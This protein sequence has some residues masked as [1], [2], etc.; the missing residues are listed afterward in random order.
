MVQQQLEDLY[1]LEPGPD[2]AHYVRAGPRAAHES[3]L[4]READGM[5]EVALELPDYLVVLTARPFPREPNSGWL[6]LIEGVSHF[7]YVAERARTDLPTTLLELELQAE[8]DKFVLLGLGGAHPGLTRIAAHEA[9][10]LYRTLYDAVRYLHPAGTILGDRYRAASDLAARF[11]V[12]L[13]AM[14]SN[15]GVLAMLRRFYRCGQ[16]DKVWLATAV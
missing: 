2:I 9:R 10:C 1:A 3:L 11:V 14:R 5:V 13:L 7:V 16:A 15:E 8:V 6:E 12:R 4:L